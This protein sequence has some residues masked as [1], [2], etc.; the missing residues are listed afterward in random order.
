MF[1]QT[2]GWFVNVLNKL[3]VFFD[4]YDVSAYLWRLLF[5]VSRNNQNHS[6]NQKKVTFVPN[7]SPP[8]PRQPY[9]RAVDIP[10]AARKAAPQSAVNLHP[11]NE[12][13]L[14]QQRT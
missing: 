4:A 13:G 7:S 6:R 9:S 3:V 1:R 2:R 10:N 11:G 12:T 14:E 8:N 5:N